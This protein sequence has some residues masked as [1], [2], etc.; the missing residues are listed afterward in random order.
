MEL[1]ARS[2]VATPNVNDSGI[3]VVENVAMRLPR[4]TIRRWVV[5][6]WLVVILV[7]LAIWVVRPGLSVE[8]LGLDGLGKDSPL[9]VIR[10]WAAGGLSPLTPFGFFSLFPT[11][12]LLILG[13]LVIA[14]VI[15]VLMLSAPSRDSQP[16]PWHFRAIG[17][18]RVPRIRV[19]VRMIL[20]LIAIVGLDLGWEI[21]AS[22]KWKLRKRYLAKA[23]GFAS[24]A[25]RARDYLRYKQGEL[26]RFEAGSTG[27]S[28]ERM[29]PAARAA[30][31]AYARDLF[32]QQLSYARDLVCVLAD[33]E[34]K[35]R[36]AAA[37][38]FRPVAADPPLPERRWIRATGID[39]RNTV[40]WCPPLMT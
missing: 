38:P 8:W 26:A 1:D 11:F 15:P 27:W 22:R 17:E 19:R 13:A 39:E 6:V 29:T 40:A 28:E 9:A 3:H 31:Q 5:E 24:E 23:Q 20:V 14:V 16:G 21:V 35:Y 2:P 4:V 10:Q 25:G 36:N 34:Q 7:L 33:L 32:G 30:E 18:L 12:D 37:D